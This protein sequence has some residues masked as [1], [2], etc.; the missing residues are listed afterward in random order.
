VQNPAKILII[1]TAFIGDVILTTPLVAAAH[2]LYPAAIIDFLTI[3]R[4]VNLLQNNPAIQNIIIFDK[5]GADKG[6]SG[7]RNLAAQLR[8]AGYDLCLTPHRSLRSAFLS[9]ASKAPVRIG[10]D[11][12]AWKYSFTEIVK[13]PVHAHEI[14]RNLA[15][16][17]P[18]GHVIPISRP[19]IY[20]TEEDKEAV[21]KQLI[22]NNLSETDALFAL[23]PGSI[24][25]T[26][27]W[28][29]EYYA[30]ICQLITDQ[31]FIPVLIGG[32]EDMDLC[33]KIVKFCSRAI[34]LAGKLTLRQTV[35]L[36]QSCKGILTNDSA[37]LHLGLAAAIPVYAIFGSTITDFGF[38][39]FGKHDR[40]IEDK[41]LACRPCGIHGRNKCP[42]K[43]FACMNN[44]R[45]EDVLKEIMN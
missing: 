23:A 28:P 16:L 39:P 40:I 37:P 15:L 6:L 34:N 38:A 17:Q 24:W 5:R 35:D 9:Y 41:A 10:F 30:Q 4:S 12:S 25:P 29:E 44:L 2:K 20:P 31:E 3:P 27:R 32:Q 26:K 14:E 7:L 18:L 36:L 8:T 43:T 19:E 1:Q 45:P 11:R 13:Y 21:K 22:D 42:L 33:N